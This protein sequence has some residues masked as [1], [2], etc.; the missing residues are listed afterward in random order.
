MLSV[1]PKTSLLSMCT[2]NFTKINGTKIKYQQTTQHKHTSL[3]PIAGIPNP[4][5]KI[6]AADVLM[7][8]RVVYINKHPH[9]ILQ[10]VAA[11]IAFSQEITLFD[12]RV[13]F[14]SHRS[15]LIFIRRISLLPPVEP[16]DPWYTDTPG[17]DPSCC[18]PSLSGYLSSS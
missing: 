2:C 1:S 8:A 18:S 16:E 7:F 14:L 11:K 6:I 3:K 9:L 4:Y 5:V 15:R 13:F 17:C 12:S 10:Y